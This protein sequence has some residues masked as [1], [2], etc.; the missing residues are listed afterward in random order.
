MNLGTMLLGIFSGV[1][2]QQYLGLYV[3]WQYHPSSDHSLYAPAPFPTGELTV[4]SQK[5]RG[6]V[7]FNP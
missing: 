4:A 6:F 1:I 2:Q 5:D 3:A 7:S